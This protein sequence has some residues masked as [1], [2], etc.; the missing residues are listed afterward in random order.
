L[1]LVACRAALLLLPTSLQIVV[2]YVALL[3]F[4]VT[5]RN[6]FLGARADKDS[7]L[8]FGSAYQVTCGEGSS[9][10]VPRTL[11]G[12]SVDQIPSSTGTCS[13]F[14]LHNHQIMSADHFTLVPMTDDVLS[15]LD[16]LAAQDRVTVTASAPFLKHGQPLPDIAG[17][18]NS[19]PRLTPTAPCMQPAAI[20]EV[21]TVDE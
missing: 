5:T 9:N 13:I 12:I 7:Q 20:N 19:S 16:A 6:D 21:T 14:M 11:R 17:F 1:L 4:P 15:R 18:E 8:E 2:P 10:M 3:S